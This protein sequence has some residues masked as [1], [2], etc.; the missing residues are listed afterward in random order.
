MRPIVLLAG[1]ALAFAASAAAAQ[2]PATIILGVDSGNV[3]VSTGGEFAPLA[4]GQAIAPGHRVMVPEGGSAHLSYSGGCQKALTTAGVYTV[5]AQCVAG[6]TRRT[7]LSNGAI[8]GIVAGVAVVAAVAS[9]GGSDDD[10]PV[11]R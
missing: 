2:E 9:G 3:L 11:S 1:F 8:A 10:V 7:G 6:S 5:T 4:P